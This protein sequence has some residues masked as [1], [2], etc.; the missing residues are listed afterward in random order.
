MGRVEGEALVTRMPISFWGGVNPKTGVVVE[1]GHELEGRSIS[2]KVLVFP[3]GKG[4]TVGSY[5]IYGL[6]KLGVAPKAIINMETEPIV[7]IGA[8]IAGIP[9]VDK[10]DKDLMV[11]KTG[12][13][14]K[15][16]ADQGI[17]EVER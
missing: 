6:A 13:H 8:I 11:I 10:P 4:S 9:V 12:D 16:N 14:V 3:Y 15:V 7:A 17:I 2:N 1:K 5:V